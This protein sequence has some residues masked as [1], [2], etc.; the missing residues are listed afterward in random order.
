MV[1]GK[2]VVIFSQLLGNPFLLESTTLLT[3]VNRLHEDTPTPQPEQEIL[4]SLTRLSGVPTFFVFSP[5]FFV[6]SPT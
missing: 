3:D 4:G 6:F 2:V 1:R 5:T